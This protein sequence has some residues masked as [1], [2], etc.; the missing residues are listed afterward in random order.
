MILPFGKCFDAHIC[1]W[2]IGVK[3]RPYIPMMADITSPSE[4]VAL[5]LVPFRGASKYVFAP[6]A[7][8]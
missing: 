3:I 8:P 7:A 6:V 1:V 2:Q 4:A 5:E